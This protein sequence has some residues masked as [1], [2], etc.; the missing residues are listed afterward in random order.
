MI[1]NIN[2]RTWKSCMVLHT[3]IFYIF[4]LVIYFLFFSISLFFYF[5]FFF[6]YQ[7]YS[8]VILEQNVQKQNFSQVSSFT[9][10]CTGSTVQFVVLGVAEVLLWTMKEYDR[11]YKKGR[12]SIFLNCAHLTERQLFSDIVMLNNVNVILLN[13]FFHFLK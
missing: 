1:L 10:H 6:L 7:Y 5:Y 11:E 12:R 9:E 13:I 4:F 3:D 2:L 8:S